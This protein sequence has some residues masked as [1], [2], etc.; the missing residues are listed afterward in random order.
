LPDKPTRVVAGIGKLLLKNV[1][2]PTIVT[3]H[4]AFPTY[5][6]AATS[7]LSWCLLAHGILI[8]NG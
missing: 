8:L 3:A 5:T 7:G 4:G 6:T 1:F 2:P